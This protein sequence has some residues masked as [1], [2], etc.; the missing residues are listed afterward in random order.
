V[1]D[2]TLRER[3]KALLRST[4][5]DEWISRA[6]YYGRLATNPVFRDFERRTHRDYLDWRERH[7]A[8]LASPLL[9]PG[10]A[11]RTALVVTKGTAVGARIELMFIKALELA[12]F[13]SLV[14]TDREFAKYYEL[15]NVAGI[16][17]W[18]Q[19]SRQSPNA[20][21]ASALAG[22]RCVEDLLPL[23]VAG[24]RVGKFALSSTF[25]SLKV[26]RLDFTD[27]VTRQ[28]L[29]EHLASGAARAEASHRLL[30]EVQPDLAIFMGNRYSGQGELMDVTLARGIDVVTWF[31]AH[32]SN[33]LML[34]RYRTDNRDRHHGSI[35]D[36]T[37][38]AL[39][40]MPW[41]PERQSEL[42][43][44]IADNYA[45]GDWYSRGGTQVNKRII[46]A[47]AIRER[48]S[49]DPA[50]KTAVIFPHIVWDATL[51]WGTDLFPN[52]EDWLVETVRAACANPRVNWIVKIHPAHVAKSAM[53]RFDGEAAEVLILR[54]RLGPLPP[55]VRVIPP[56]T[57]INT[58]S[59]FAVMDY[60][61]TVRGTIGIEA[62]SLGITVLT[63]GSGRYDRRGFTLDFG[64]AAAY[65]STLSTIETLPAP[66][67]SERELA[68]RFAYGAFLARPFRCHTFTIEHAKD[69]EATTH[70]TL[71]AETPEQLRSAPDLA[72]LARWM[73]NPFAEDFL[74][75]VPAPV[76]AAMTR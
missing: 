50:K 71:H 26:G 40:E 46:D 32:R 47:A 3:V 24:A 54:N 41:A 62:A 14:L 56:D 70:V 7:R 45:A 44:E 8:L 37:W 69:I 72:A 57:D 53:E 19:F 42:R 5:A 20:R 6:R 17:R 4:G 10:V 67:A 59:L 21:M 49:L 25:R 52:Y 39:C 33:S 1:T 11:P 76:N 22:A 13:R 23:E 9:P 35:A 36:D 61:L 12:G 68:E 31:D 63:A 65:L 73:A 43:A 27:P 2:Q 60:C 75:P 51:F 28:T 18:E 30:D 15:A 29:G 16:V 48:L 66:N 38:A 74:Q 55:H 34:K 64:T 58:Y